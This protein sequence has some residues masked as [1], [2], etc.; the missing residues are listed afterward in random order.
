MGSN[1]ADLVWQGG[2]FADYLGLSDKVTRTSSTHWRERERQSE[3]ARGGGG[4]Y[5]VSPPDH[6]VGEG[7]DP[8]DRS[9]EGDRKEPG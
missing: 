5:L 9:D 3:R 7:G 4:G 8:A 2:E 6:Q 1:R